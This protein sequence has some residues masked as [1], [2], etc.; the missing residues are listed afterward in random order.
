MNPYLIWFLL[1]VACSPL[2]ALI[3][4]Y[5]LREHCTLANGDPPGKYFWLVPCIVE[6]VI[7]SIGLYVGYG[8]G[9]MG[10]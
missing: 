6:T 8:I 2:I 1:P 3:D 4:F 7:F 5:A 9:G 10:L